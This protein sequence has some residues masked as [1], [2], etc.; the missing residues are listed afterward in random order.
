[1]N[2]IM[3][4]LVTSVE[5][6]EKINF[7]TFKSKLFYLNKIFIKIKYQERICLNN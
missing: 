5:K 7:L 2:R 1:M 6:Q 3:S 4:L